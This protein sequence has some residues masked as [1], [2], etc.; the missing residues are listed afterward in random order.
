MSETDHFFEEEKA[1]F[2]AETPELKAQP[3][4]LNV[5]MI[6]NIILFAGI[7]LCLILIFTGKSKNSKLPAR[8]GTGL[9]IAFINSDTLMSQYEL[10]QDLKLE[11][12]AETLKMT[13]D[14]AQKK[15]ALENQF[16]SYQNKVQAGTISIDDARKTEESLSRQQQELMNL[17]DVY[18]NQISDKEYQM[19]LQVYDSL[20]IVLKLINETENFDYILGYSKGAGILYANP[21]HDVTAM[22][23]E[24]LNERYLKSKK[25]GK[26]DK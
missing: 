13:Q 11:L 16:I 19:S 10:F 6:L 23:V 8:D 15:K 14:L 4:K 18:T 7:I 22:V 2:S 21:E 26:K 1:E 12:E 3:K 5:Q 20:N 25:N 17:S 9:S 24:I